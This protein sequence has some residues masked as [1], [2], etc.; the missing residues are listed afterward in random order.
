[1]LDRYC[2]WAAVVAER[3]CA[4]GFDFYVST[5][6][7][8]HK[9]GPVFSPQVFHDLVLPRYQKVAEKISLPWVVHSDG[10]IAP[11]LPDLLS[12]P[13]SAIHPVERAAMDIREL[14]TR[15]GKRLCLMG[16]VDLN[17]LSE[18]TPQDVADEVRALIRDVGSDGGYILSSGNS[19]PEYVRPANARAMGAT[20]VR[21]G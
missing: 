21:Y 20:V 6:D 14:K 1:V 17:I 4:M 7:M 13:V 16:N 8:A 15:Y 18:G 10:N 19:L 12:L 9:S 5:D 3:V 11:L 2:N